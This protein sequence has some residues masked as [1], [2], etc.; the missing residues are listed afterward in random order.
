MAFHRFLDWFGTKVEVFYIS[1]LNQI[2]ILMKKKYIFTLLIVGFLFFSATT[3][4]Q[5]SMSSYSTEVL[6]DIDGL[7][8]YPNP[9]SNGKIYITSTLNKPK[10][11][12]IYDVLG[13]MAMSETIIGKELNVSNLNPGVYILRIKEN[14]LS[15]TRKLVV[16]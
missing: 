14:D 4:A 8:I 16:R 11:V 7:S 3:F 6:K 9:V 13:K 1:L 5:Q 10:E 2:R 15:T 12:K